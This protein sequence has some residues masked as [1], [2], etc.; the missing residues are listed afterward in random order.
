MSWFLE[1]NCVRQTSRT[2]FVWN[3]SGLVR[4]VKL[5]WL[6]E[7]V[8]APRRVVIGS[9][10]PHWTITTPWG[11]CFFQWWFQGPPILGHPYGKLPILFPYHSHKNPL[12]YWISMGTIRGC[13][14]WESL[15]IPLTRG[16]GPWFSVDCHRWSNICCFVF[17]VSTDWGKIEFWY[18]AS[19]WVFFWLIVMGIVSLIWWM[20][21]DILEGNISD[22][23]WATP[24][25]CWS[26]FLWRNG[27]RSLLW[28]QRKVQCSTAFFND[29]IEWDEEV[30]LHH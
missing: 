6:M 25:R 1:A 7:V 5:R 2:W 30:K 15:K 17:L 23:P 24:F 10:W 29:W 28:T 18:H 13:H 20:E 9:T 12:R 8:R 11:R 27:Y 16:Q 19:T 4:I 3:E 26:S 22:T 21:V 14:Y